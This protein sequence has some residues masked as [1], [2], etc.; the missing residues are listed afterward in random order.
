MRDDVGLGETWSLFGPRSLKCSL[1]IQQQMLRRQQGAGSRTQGKGWAGGKTEGAVIRKTI[2]SPKSVY[3]MTEGC[4]GKKF[5][6]KRKFECQKAR[7]SQEIGECSQ[8]RQRK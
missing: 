8:P 5:S 2:R 7:A 3:R 4:R 6:L 1:D